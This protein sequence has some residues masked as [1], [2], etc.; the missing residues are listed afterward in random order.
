MA[1]KAE[2]RFMTLSEAA[3]KLGVTPGRLR[4]LAQQGR[5][6]GARKVG[7][8]WVIPTNVKIIQNMEDKN[9]K[10]KLKMKA[11]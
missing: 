11:V 9:R 7:R 10:K 4:Q 3:I 6:L 8:A 1:F 2:G 5:V